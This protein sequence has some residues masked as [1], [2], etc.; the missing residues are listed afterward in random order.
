MQARIGLGLAGLAIFSVAMLP[1]GTEPPMFPF[2]DKL[3]HVCAFALLAVLGRMSWPAAPRLWLAL[4]LA[5][6]G[7]LIE[8][9]Q[10]MSDLGRTA[11]LFDVL[12][13]LVGIGLGFVL[14]DTLRRLRSRLQS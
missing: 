2:E 8:L 14:F 5:G 12:A 4:G 6:F 1:S 11:S 3:K 9:A 13:D 7:F 10:G